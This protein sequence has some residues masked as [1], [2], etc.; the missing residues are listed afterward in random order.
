MRMM[1]TILSLCLTRKKEL[2]GSKTGGR[3]PV[4]MVRQLLLV[5]F[6]AVLLAQTPSIAGDIVVDGQLISTVGTGTPPLDVSSMTWVQNL[7]ADLLD[8]QDASDFS[9]VNHSHG[10]LGIPSGAVMFFDLA[11]CPTDWTL[12]SGAQGRYLVGGTTI[13][14]QVGSALSDGEDRATGS[15]IHPVTD[16]GHTHGIN[17]HGHSVSDP[18]HSHSVIESPHSHSIDLDD[19]FGMGGV[20]DA[21]ESSEGSD[22]TGTETTGISIG[23]SATG[24]S[25]LQSSSGPTQS[26]TTGVVTAAPAGT[27][28]G[29]NAPYLQLLVCK[30][31][32]GFLEHLRSLE[33]TAKKHPELAKSAATAGNSD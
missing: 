11:N 32:F 1:K 24:V 25:V 17:P 15:H 4:P 22:S 9:L 14:M 16:T 2:S 21:G 6:A 19:N 29:T 8:N 18:D 28:A 13:G 20:D 31:D 30:K 33:E 10:N 5:A 26:A 7:N 3:R 23:S 12:L 27:V